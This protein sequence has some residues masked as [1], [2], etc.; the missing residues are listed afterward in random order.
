MI[1]IT[2]AMLTEKKMKLVLGFSFKAINALNT[3]IFIQS[4]INDNP[5]APIISAIWMNAVTLA[6]P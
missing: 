5:N 3:K 2:I 1:I 4:T 6:K